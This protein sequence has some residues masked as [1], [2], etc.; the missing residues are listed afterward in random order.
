MFNTVI[1]G[2]KSVRANARCSDI[3]SKLESLGFEIRDGKRGGHKIFVHDHLPSFRSGSFNCGHGNNPEIKP[4]YIKK[5]VRLLLEHE[6]D[7]KKYL[8]N[9]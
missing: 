7:L 4:V 3:T 8:S 2:L 1:Q 6:C 5:L 9:R